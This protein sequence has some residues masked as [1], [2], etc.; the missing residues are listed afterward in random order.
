MKI[1]YDKEVIKSNIIEVWEAIPPSFFMKH[2]DWYWEYHNWCKNL[3][4]R[5]GIPLMPVTAVFAGLSPQCSIRQNKL[6]TEAYF[7][8]FKKHTKSQIS[9]CDRIVAQYG[10]REEQDEIIQKLFIERCLNGLKT[11]N[12]FQALYN[13]ADP[14]SCCIDR[15]ALNVAGINSLTVTNKQYQFI[16]ECYL[17]VSEELNILCNSLQAVTW[18]YIRQSKPNYHQFN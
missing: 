6:F 12:F 9:K 11:V 7:A 5:V 13:P 14:T 1:L 16:K 10:Y 8:G 15:H 3:S 4:K 18:E 17:E 2:K